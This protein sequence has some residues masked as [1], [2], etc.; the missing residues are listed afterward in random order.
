MP[1]QP[2]VLAFR[3]APPDRQAP[4]AARTPDVLLGPSAS[5]THVWSQIRRVAPYFRTALLTGE[6]GSGTEAAAQALHQLSPLNDRPFIVMTPADCEARLTGPTSPRF[7]GDTLFFPEVDHLSAAA[8]Q[9]LLRI[10]RHRRP[11]QVCVIAAAQ[12]DLRPLVSAGSF[13]SV[14]ATQLSALHIAMPPLRER[15]EDI[16]ALA[17][18]LITQ[19]ARAAGILTP[20]S[21]TPELLQVLSEHPWPGNL[22]QLQTVLRRLLRRHPNAAPDTAAL[23]SLLEDSHTPTTTPIEPVRLLKLD[24]VIQEHIRAVLLRC[25]GNKLRAAEVLGI[26][27]STLYRM[28]DTQN[29]SSSSEDNDI[30]L[31]M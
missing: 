25:N 27:R 9:S 26:S 3:V 17:I 4:D 2:N 18:H 29:A 31:A 10:L 20:P 15:Q 22:D 16:P 30:S 28:L 11:H 1:P 5:I 14:L 12:G 7:A 24:Q 8:Q 6:R 21:I 13:S 19:E 23:R